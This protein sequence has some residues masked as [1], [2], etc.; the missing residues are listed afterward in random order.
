MTFKVNLLCTFVFVHWFLRSLPR[1]SCVWTAAR[2]FPGIDTLLWAPTIPHSWLCGCLFWGC[3]LLLLVFFLSSPLLRKGR[4]TSPNDKTKREQ[5]SCSFGREFQLLKNLFVS[6]GRE[7]GELGM[8]HH[9]MFLTLERKC[10]GN[11]RRTSAGR[12]RY[13]S[14]GCSSQVTSRSWIHH[15]PF[16]SIFQLMT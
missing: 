3:F 15:R 16:F 4:R 14:C 1:L 13:N 2:G 9:A 7:S 10:S 6:D 5:I 11:V 8:R 12:D